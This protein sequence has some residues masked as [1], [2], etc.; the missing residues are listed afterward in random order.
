[1]V[2]IHW[3]TIGENWII[4]TRYPKKSKY[5]FLS[6]RIPIMSSIFCKYKSFQ[7]W[8]CPIS[9]SLTSK[10]CSGGQVVASIET[11]VNWILW[12]TNKQV[13]AMLLH[14]IVDKVFINGLNFYH[15]YNWN[16]CFVFTERKHTYKKFTLKFECRLQ[17]CL[18]FHRPLFSCQDVNSI[19]ISLIRTSPQHLLWQ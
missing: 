19:N 4:D 11:T 17:S 14:L 12:S 6:L 7:I 15:I 9:I 16:K 3:A 13:M 1:M 18:P 8:P 5:G 2:L 10:Y